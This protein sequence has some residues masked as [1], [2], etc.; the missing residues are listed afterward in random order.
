MGRSESLTKAPSGVHHPSTKE[1]GCSAHF[2]VL[3]AGHTKLLVIVKVASVA[4]TQKGEIAVWT[5]LHAD[6]GE[7]Q[8]RTYRIRAEK[9]SGTEAPRDAYEESS[10]KHQ[11]EEVKRIT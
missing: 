4:R 11:G 6:L 10:G 3:E 9:P 1:V 2:I 5:L 8:G 7:A